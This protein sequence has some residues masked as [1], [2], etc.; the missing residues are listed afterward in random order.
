MEKKE[1]IKA[2]LRKDPI[3]CGR[4][5]CY[6]TVKMTEAQYEKCKSNIDELHYHNGYPVV[7]SMDEAY[8]YGKE[9]RR[10]F[11]KQGILDI[12]D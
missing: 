12:V 4:I 8:Y 2:V 3:G 6:K 10:H 1:Y 5:I 11:R 9:I 7:E